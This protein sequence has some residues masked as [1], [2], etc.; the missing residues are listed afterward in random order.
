VSCY[1]GSDTED[2][3]LTIGGV[4][5]PISWSNNLLFPPSLGTLQVFPHY[6]VSF[7]VRQ[8]ESLLGKTLPKHWI[9]VPVQKLG[10]WADWW[11]HSL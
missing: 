5:P 3:A 9:G 7:V 4:G 1:F 11:V 8:W 10:T 6:L 2:T